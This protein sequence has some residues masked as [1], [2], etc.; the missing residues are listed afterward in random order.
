MSDAFKEIP[1]SEDIETIRNPKEQQNVEVEAW[2]T[3]YV[4]YLLNIMPKSWIIGH[5]LSILTNQSTTKLY[6]QF[7]FLPSTTLISLYLSW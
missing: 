5:L 1:N 7:N 2:F 3:E 4:K 6:F